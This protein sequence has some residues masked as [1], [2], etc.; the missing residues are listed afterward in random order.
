[1]RLHSWPGNIRDQK[2][3]VRVA[4]LK[5][6]R[7]IITKNRLELDKPASSVKMNFR[8]MYL[9]FGGTFRHIGEDA[10]YL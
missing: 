1:M 3:V 10:D 6:H 4:V 2:H 8:V 9:R 5:T 7:S